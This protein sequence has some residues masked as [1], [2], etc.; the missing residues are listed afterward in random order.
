MARGKVKTE[1]EKSIDEMA[2]ELARKTVRGMY[3]DGKLTPQG[4]SLVK[5]MDRIMPDENVDEWGWNLSRKERAAI[6]RRVAEKKVAEEKKKAEARARVA[7][8]RRQRKLEENG[9]L[10]G[11]VQINWAFMAACDEL[12][13][14]GFSLELMHKLKGDVVARISPWNKLHHADYVEYFI[15]QYY[16]SCSEVQIET[17]P[18]NQQ[19]AARKGWEKV[20]C[21]FKRREPWL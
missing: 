15:Y 12:K 7:Y 5:L 14:R 10:E 2:D 21:P 19:E 9:L 11:F 17:L 1:E 4:R 16:L 13:R 6:K 18:A 8:R 20:L 3:K